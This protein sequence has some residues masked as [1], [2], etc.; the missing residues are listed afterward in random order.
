MIL[1]ENF[2]KNHLKI[3]SFTDYGN[4]KAR[5]SGRIGHA[6]DT[7]IPEE[8]YDILQSEIDYAE[9]QAKDGE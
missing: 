4:K 1:V 9:K 3:G 2:I 7:P 8:I 5:K 6:L